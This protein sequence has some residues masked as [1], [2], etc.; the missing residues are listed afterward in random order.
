MDIV[1]RLEALLRSG[2]SIGGIARVYFSAK[3]V[4]EIVDEI[5]R[6]RQALAAEREECA[7]VAEKFDFVV[8]GKVVKNSFGKDV[9]TLTLLSEPAIVHGIAAAIRSRKKKGE[10]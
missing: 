4:R 3:D 6:L 5:L 10:G 2:D 1:E 9:A 8:P 7:K